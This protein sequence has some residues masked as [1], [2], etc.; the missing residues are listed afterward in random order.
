M[1]V[2]FK[3][4]HFKK[5]SSTNDQAKTLAEKGLID[6]VVVADEQTKG[7][8]RFNRKWISSLGGLYFS[9][10]LKEKNTDKI[11]YLTFIAAISVVKAIFQ[12]TKLKTKI[13]WPNDIHINNRK[14]C[15]ILTENVLGKVNQVIVG[16]GINI[17]QSKFN[18]KI[19]NIATS[20]KIE[21][22][23]KTNKEKILSHFLKEFDKLYVQYKNEEYARILKLFKEN[24]DTIG[25]NVK[26]KTLSEIFCGKVIDVDEDCNLILKL[27]DGKLKKII[28]GDISIVD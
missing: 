5:I 17:N 8:G 18:K 22:N 27:D 25:K 7:R 28:E 12:S 14:L 16:A 6:V 26:V 24:C 10:L 11:K 13:K 1:K 23:K 19:S 4:Y 15:G 3:I 20:L 9:V 21:L 2:R